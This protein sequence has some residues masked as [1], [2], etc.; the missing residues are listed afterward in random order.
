MPDYDP[1]TYPPLP[2]LAYLRRGYK[3]NAEGAPNLY[4]I[5]GR[6]PFNPI[7]GDWPPE[8]AS[9]TNEW[10]DRIG[11]FWYDGKYWHDHHYAATTDPGD[12]HAEYDPNQRG[13]AVMKPGQYVD[14][15]T[16]GKHRG[17]PA[18]VNWGLCAP[19]YWR[20]V[21]D[22]TGAPFVAAEGRE[23]IGLNIHRS[24][25]AGEAPDSV[26]PY[27]KGCQVIQL[28]LD[29]DLYLA[30]VRYLAGLA[31]CDYLTYTLLTEGDVFPAD[32]PQANTNTPPDH[33]TWDGEFY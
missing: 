11:V 2:A 14:A 32:A 23:Y 12:N 9:Q 33:V 22:L 20:I 18:I 1:E 21:K 6:N 28:P 25:L 26:G 8:F 13:V 19:D 24:R 30:K 31:N 7:T 4:G 5:R 16:L 27:S 15:Y 29:Y 3:F 10:D 17:H